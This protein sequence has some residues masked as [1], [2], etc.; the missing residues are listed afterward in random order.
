M[1]R[2]IIKTPAAQG[3]TIIRM[4]DSVFEYRSG[5]EVFGAQYVLPGEVFEVVEETN[6]WIVDAF[7]AQG[8]ENDEAC[9]G[10]V[11]LSEEQQIEAL[12]R[13]SLVVYDIPND[14]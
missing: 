2:I 13:R 14:Y 8:K 3:G 12:T 5:A 7:I 1:F 9:R 10:G 11:A 4:D 6:H